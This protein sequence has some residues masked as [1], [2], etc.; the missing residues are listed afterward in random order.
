MDTERHTYRNF[1]I[2]M[3]RTSEGGWIARVFRLG[4]TSPES[5]QVSSSSPTSHTDVLD[6][7][8]AIVDRLS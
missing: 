7:A 5:E 3:Q 8:K 1:N 4:S 6:R 2:D